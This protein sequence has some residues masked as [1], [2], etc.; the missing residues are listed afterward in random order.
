MVVKVIIFD[1]DGTIADTLSTIVSITN[2]LAREFNY[3]PISP[4]DLVELKNLNSRQIIHQSGIST[5]KLPFVMRKIK[6]ELNR[7]IQFLK[8]ISGIQATLTELKLQDIRLGIVTSN[9]KK[10]VMS[11][12]KSNNLW[13]LFDFVYSSLTLFGKDKVITRILRAEQ[14]LLT[15]VVYVGDETR[16]IEAAKKINIKVI[17]VGWGFNSKEVLANQNP[18]FL[19]HHPNQL[20]D[21]IK[22]LQLLEGIRG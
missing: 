18:D 15:E 3:R 17:A 13:D 7:E 4:D 9:S 12:L 2:R 10:N 8:P 16:D 5:F 14:L 20:I 19:I 21:T 22:Y 11:F 6:A 1:F